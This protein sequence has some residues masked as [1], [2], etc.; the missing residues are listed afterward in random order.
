[1]KKVLF[2]FLLLASR[3][4]ATGFFATQTGGGSANGTSGNPWSLATFNSL[5]SGYVGG[6]TIFF[7]GTITTCIEPGVSG[8][9][10]NQ[11]IIDCSGAS[12]TPAMSGNGAQA[13]HIRTD[14]VTYYGGGSFSGGSGNIK[15]FTTG[16]TITMPATISGSYPYNSCITCG[17][18]GASQTGIIIDGFKFIGNGTDQ[19][20][21]FISVSYILSLTLK[22]CYGTGGV[23]FVVG[24][25]DESV[26]IQNNYWVTGTNTVS[27][28]D[29]IHCGDLKNFTIEG[30]YFKNIA[31]NDVV[32]RHNDVIQTYRSG[33]SGNHAPYGLIIRYNWLEVNSVGDGNSSILMLE[34]LTDNGATTGLTMYANICVGRVT[35]NSNNGDTLNSQI[36]TMTARFYNNT[37]IDP[38]NVFG[39]GGG[40][41]FLVGSGTNTLY[42]ENNILADTGTSVAGVY[43][44]NSFTVGVLDYNAACNLASGTGGATFAGAH[45]STSA[46][47]FTNVGSDDYSLASNSVHR[48]A[49]DS[50]IGSTYNQGL[51]VGCTFPNPSLASRGATWD[52]G[53]YQS[54][55]QS[56]GAVG[57]GSFRLTGPFKLN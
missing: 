48:N 4:F 8:S 19:L 28:T 41:R 55:F 26:L 25:V 22:N 10:G 40:I 29:I 34:Q 35:T 9:A 17:Q 15:S 53:A 21:N 38:N 24:D 5:S 31:P 30:N 23:D 7:T 3:L 56:A 27:E 18:S 52:R 43:F 44:E 54:G 11:I 1:M 16:G 6:D 37:I 2:F 51:A 20:G 39:G 36:S 12:L 45:G 33:S 32:S 46:A 13:I 42:A 50:T 57:T 49:G 14:Y 47:N